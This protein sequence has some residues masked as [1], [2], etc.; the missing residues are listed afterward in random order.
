MYF[1]IHIQGAHIMI[2]I[3]NFVK[4]V[5]LLKD[6]AEDPSFF[7]PGYNWWT[8]WWRTGDLPSTRHRLMSY[9][10]RDHTP[11]EYVG[12]DIVG[13]EHWA[14][15]YDG[16]DQS[17][18]VDQS[19]APGVQGHPIF[20][21]IHHM[22]KDE[23]HWNQTGEI[24]TPAVGTIFYPVDHD[25]DGGYLRIYDT[26]EVDL[27]APYELIAPKFNRLI[28]FDPSQLHAVEEV[29]RGVRYAIAINLWEDMP[30]DGQMQDMSSI[31]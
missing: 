20:S 21:L 2:V 7:N 8:G 26:H 13:L 1:K 19:N 16:A 17:H 25:C 14:G 18:K 12:L 3:D 6:I 28:I 22:D 31:I 4:D 24:R 11:Q 5:Q 27:S 10:W 9:I 15:R 23:H 30:S 29:T